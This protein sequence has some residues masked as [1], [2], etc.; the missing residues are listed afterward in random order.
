M[1]WVDLRDRS[2][3]GLDMGEQ[4]PTGANAIE[5]R[6]EE[7]SQLF[8]SLDPFPFREKDLDKD[9]EEFIVS[10]ARELP[11]DQALRIVV[12][13]PESQASMP[14]A[15]ELAAALTRYFAYRAQVIALD[16]K[17]LFRV[18]RATH[19]WRHLPVPAWERVRQQGSTHR[20]R[21]RL[22]GMPVGAGAMGDQQK[23]AWKYRY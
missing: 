1:L 2:E 22:S 16:L 11:V 23:S 9:A 12:H 19:F 20:V 5:I 10:W 14:E 18:G 21:G 13:L 15:H 6:I 7:L 4:P 3:I 17:E 8:H